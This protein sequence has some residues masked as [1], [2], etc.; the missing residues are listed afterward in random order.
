MPTCNREFSTPFGSLSLN[1]NGA[2]NNWNCSTV[3][4][5]INAPGNI[6]RRKNTQPSV[7]SENAVLVCNLMSVTLKVITAH[8]SSRL[9]RATPT[10]WSILRATKHL[11]S[12]PSCNNVKS[13]KRLESK[14]NSWNRA[15]SNLLSHYVLLNVAYS[16]SLVFWKQINFLSIRLHS[17]SISRAVLNGGNHLKLLI[18]PHCS[19]QQ[20]AMALFNCTSHRLLVQFIKW[21][22]KQLFYP[23]LGTI[24]QHFNITGLAKL[25]QKFWQDVKHI[26]DLS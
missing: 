22:Q 5:K 15:A 10:T 9:R 25:K 4:P 1:I 18:V 8:T 26:L 24:V 14:R 6:L 13:D 12:V 23:L 11:T 3:K 2:L 20:F 7:R 16:E 17:F 19:P 21:Q